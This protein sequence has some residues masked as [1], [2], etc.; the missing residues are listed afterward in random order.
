MSDRVANRAYF[1]LGSN[2][3]PEHNLPAALSELAEF[4]EIVRVS[5][6]WQSAPVGFSEQADFLNAAALIETALSATALCDTA[7]AIEDRLK[8][9]R[10]PANKN[11]ARTID[12]DLSLFNQETFSVRGRVIPDPDLLSRAFVAVP[13]AELEPTYR[14]PL[15]NRTLSQI[16][17]E[18]LSTMPLCLRSDV[19]LDRRAE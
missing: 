11:A 12:V 14:H 1:S 19:V 6:V 4:G 16:A 18:L 8:R 7:K 15:V 2:I 13:L 10:D 9:V 3:R 5:R 17:A